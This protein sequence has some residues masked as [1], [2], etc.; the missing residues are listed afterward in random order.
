[1]HLTPLPKAWMG[2]KVTRGPSPLVRVC[3]WCP[4]RKE[5][6][7]QARAAGHEV[8]HGICPSCFQEQARRI[9]GEISD[10]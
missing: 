4:D 3:S 8:T 2:Y 7:R 10:D 5:A 1:M 6:E 9:T